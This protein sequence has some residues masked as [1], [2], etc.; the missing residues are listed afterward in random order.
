M[1][2]I[3]RYESSIAPTEDRHVAMVAFA[4]SLALANANEQTARAYARAYDSFMTYFIATNANAITPAVVNGY[5]GSLRSAGRRPSTLNQHLSAI[6][7]LVSELCA[8]GLMDQVRA[9]AIKDIKSQPKLGKRLGNW[10]TADQMTAAVNLPDVTTLKGLRDRALL[11]VLFGA[12]LRRSEVCA[13]KVAH[14]QMRDN[15]WLIVD[16]VGKRERVRSVPMA[17][18]IKNCIDA[19]LAAS[20]ATGWLFPTMSKGNKIG[21]TP[22]T[23]DGIYLL[24]K[25]YAGIAPHDARRTFARTAR[26]NGAEIDQIQQSLGHSSVATTETYLGT[27]QDLTRAPSDYIYVEIQQAP[28]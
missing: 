1:T 13:L 27:K 21:A 17:T 12:G 20:G 8:N 18:W 23:A 3:I 16:I 14:I 4:Q 28:G 5:L 15:R 2:E 6:K 26:R 22:I 19:W 25:Q 9:S 11:A 24:T 10:L 7:R